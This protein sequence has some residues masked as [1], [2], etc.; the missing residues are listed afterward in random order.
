MKR[1]LVIAA[2]LCLPACTNEEPGPTDVPP[3]AEQ[4]ADQPAEG[5]PPAEQPPAGQQPAAGAIPAGLE[6]FQPVLGKRL[7][8]AEAW[9]QANPT[10]A[11]SDPSTPVVSVRPIRIDGEELARTMD[12][13]GD[14]LNVIVENGVITGIDGVY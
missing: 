2:L 1:T 10:T 13:R 9:L 6:A 4:P 7:E 8:E 5:Q 3:A 11:A 14:R 12:L